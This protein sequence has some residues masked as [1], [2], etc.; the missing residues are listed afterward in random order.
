M[1]GVYTSPIIYLNTNWKYI[2]SEN[3]TI[4]ELKDKVRD[5][6]LSEQLY[7]HGNFKLHAALYLDHSG[8]EQFG[9]IVIDRRYDEPKKYIQSFSS[10]FCPDDKKDWLGQVLIRQLAETVKTSHDNTMSEIRKA[11]DK[12]ENLLNM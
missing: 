1:G 3:G 8:Y 2:M 4:L 12:Y 7:D 11:R 9:L 5:I 10:K 6:P